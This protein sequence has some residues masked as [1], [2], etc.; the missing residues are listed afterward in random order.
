MCSQNAH[1]QWTCVSIG[2]G[3]ATYKNNSDIIGGQAAKIGLIIGPSISLNPITYMHPEFL[4][5]TRH[6]E[7]IKRRQMKASL[8]VKLAQVL[9]DSSPAMRVC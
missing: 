4:T 6:L 3:A 2:Y 5:P 8:A 9:S 7:D 1:T